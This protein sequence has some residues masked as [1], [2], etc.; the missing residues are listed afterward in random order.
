MEGT[1]ALSSIHNLTFVC[2]FFF[3]S[4]NSHKA[5]VPVQ[6]R[7]HHVFFFG[8]ISRIPIKFHKSRSSNTNDFP[9]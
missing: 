4:S 1:E 2:H 5:H 3:V 7:G 8:L 6:R 9:T